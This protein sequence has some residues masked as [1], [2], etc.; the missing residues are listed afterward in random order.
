MRETINMTAIVRL[1]II[2]IKLVNLLLHYQS[3]RKIVNK[4]VLYM[5]R[6]A[7]LD[8]VGGWKRTGWK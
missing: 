5:L 4:I 6:Q 3:R 7:Q 1:I 2:C 8:I